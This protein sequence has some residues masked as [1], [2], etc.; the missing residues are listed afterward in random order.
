MI[1]LILWLL[2]GSYGALLL[3]LS[4]IIHDDDVMTLGHWCG[5]VFLGPILGV[6]TLVIAILVY[7]FKTG[8]HM[9]AKQL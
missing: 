2:C 4:D 6:L 8:P 7:C 3:V 1:W 5:Y 9:L